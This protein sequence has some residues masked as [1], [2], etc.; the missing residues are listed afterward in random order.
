MSY[1]TDPKQSC[2]KHADKYFLLPYIPASS[3]DVQ[4]SVA[5]LN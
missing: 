2:T 4:R 5:E 3:Y 1:F